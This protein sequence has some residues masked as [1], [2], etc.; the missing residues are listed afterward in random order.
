MALIK[1]KNCNQDISDK[2]VVCPKC[3]TK[4]EKSEPRQVEQISV[5]D[6]KNADEEVVRSN[7]NQVKNC[8]IVTKT[9]LIMMAIVCVAILGMIVSMT[10]ALSYK[11][12]IRQMAQ[13]NNK[14]EDQVVETVNVEDTEDVVS[15]TAGDATADTTEETEF[16]VKEDVV[17]VES[18]EI[19]SQSVESE[20]DTESKGI[21]D[22]IVRNDYSTDTIAQVGNLKVDT[23]EKKDFDAIFCLTDATVLENNGDETVKVGIKG[24]IVE[25]LSGYETVGITV[26]F[27]DENGFEIYS[28]LSYYSN[29]VGPF[30]ASFSK[31]PNNVAAVSLK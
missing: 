18:E 17:E 19:E 12:A 11:S 26:Q 29:V 28:S 25:N 4:V 23:T 16:E 31:V 21:E 3:G 27:L 13:V 10:Y 22:S 8:I 24:E 30:T 2:A 6:L 14:K 1:C 20:E 5:N 9:N 7:G 15:E